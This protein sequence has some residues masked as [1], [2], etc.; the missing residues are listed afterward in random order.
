MVALSVP[1]SIIGGVRSIPG[2]GIVGAGEDT[3][4]A[5][6]VQDIGNKEVADVWVLH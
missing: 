4:V 5:V 3:V 2:R 6:L 1:L